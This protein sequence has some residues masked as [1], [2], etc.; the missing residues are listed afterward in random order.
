MVLVVKCLI[1]SKELAYTQSDPSELISHVK[2]EHPLV[3]QRTTR[4]ATKKDKI[5]LRQSLDLNAKSFKELIDREIQTDINWKDFYKMNPQPTS[6]KQSSSTNRSSASES[7]TVSKISSPRGSDSRRKSNESTPLKPQSQRRES[8][9]L[10]V[11]KNAKVLYSRGSND[12]NRNFE[13]H[14]KF[15]KTSIETWRPVG[16]QKINCPRCK[17]IKRPIV[18]THKE[19]KTESSFMSTLFMTCWPCCFSPCMFP[20]PSH[21]NLHCPVCDFH[22]GIYDHN[23]KTVVS[24]PRLSRDL[25]H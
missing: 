14:V 8:V 13:K 3:N 6:S 9:E 4:K 16:D 11:G 15:Y 22:L 7:V 24:N 19:R 1:C 18:R 12:S 23:L 21:E 20:E 5:D 10:K 2:S 25:F 17:S